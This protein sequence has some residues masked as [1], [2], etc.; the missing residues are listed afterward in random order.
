MKHF[1]GI[2]LERKF[3]LD[4]KYYFPKKSRTAYFYKES[5][6]LPSVQLTEKKTELAMTDDELLMIL[7]YVD[8]ANQVSLFSTFILCVNISFISFS[9]NLIQFFVL[10]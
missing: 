5:V 2:F 8:R 10:L 1:E 7:Q 9:F 4:T 6:I 3:D